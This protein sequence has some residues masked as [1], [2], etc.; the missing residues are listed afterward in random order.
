MRVQT[1]VIDWVEV[2][3]GVLIRGTPSVEI[4]E[5][6]QRHSDYGLPHSYFAKEAPQSEVEVTA[7]NISRTPVTID[8]WRSFCEVTGWDAPAGDGRL[9]IERL[10][11]WQ[12][13]A[14]CEWASDAT[15]VAARL[16]SEDEWERA[17]RGD[18]TREY[19]WG[20]VFERRCANLAELGVG[21]A[22][23]VGSLPLGASPFGVL[24]MAGNTDEWTA[25]EYYRYPGGPDGLPDVEDHAFDRHITRGGGYIHCKDLARCARR[26]G[27]YEPGGGAGFRV[28]ASA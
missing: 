5:V 17:A 13:Q 12:A 7:F 6:V 16:V 11:W 27:V 2:P 4:D 14:F 24:D 25:T 22:L 28:A 20:N 19:P 9:P 8:Q 21:H 3:R 18:D 15:G 23:P 1:L 10:A 26:H